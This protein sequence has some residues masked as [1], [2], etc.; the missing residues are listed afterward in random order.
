MYLRVD[1]SGGGGGWRRRELL[2]ALKA[3]DVFRS[4]TFS[5]TV[6]YRI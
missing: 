4:F 5:H 2:L 6:E 1:S 3:N